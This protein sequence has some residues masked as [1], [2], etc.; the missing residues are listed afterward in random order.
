MAAVIG[1]FFTECHST[2]LHILSNN[3]HHPFHPVL[4][5]ILVFSNLQILPAVKTQ[6]EKQ[7]KH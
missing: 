7:V 4:S 5:N 1:F 6:Q 3:T 2:F